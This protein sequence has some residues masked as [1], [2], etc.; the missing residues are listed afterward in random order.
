MIL[1]RTA[2]V[3]TIFSLTFSLQGFAGSCPSI[4]C[5]IGFSCAPE[6][7]R[8]NLAAVDR[9]LNALADSHE[10]AGETRFRAQVTRIREISDDSAKTRE[11]L[12]LVGLEELSPEQVN[13]FIGARSVDPARVSAI[14]SAASLSELKAKIVVEAVQAAMLG[15]RL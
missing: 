4:G 11:Y 1:F 9:T 14:Q 15:E 12:R 5:I 6:V 7:A 8:G 13:Q 10:F 3:M 2:F